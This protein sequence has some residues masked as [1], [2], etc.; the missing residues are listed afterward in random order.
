MKFDWQSIVTLPA[1]EKLVLGATH[2]MIQSQPISAS[3]NINWAMSVQSNFFDSLRHLGGSCDD[4]DRFGSK[5]T[6]PSP[7]I[8]SLTSTKIKASI[9]AG[10]K[11][12][13]CPVVSSFPDFFFLN[14][15]DQ[16]DLGWDAGF[17]QP[18]TTVCVSA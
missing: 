18:P 5:V 13:H 7:G 9:G 6:Y 3:T 17:K 11:R 2:R 15:L 14:E 12:P 8:S 4:N 10:L 16:T 1:N